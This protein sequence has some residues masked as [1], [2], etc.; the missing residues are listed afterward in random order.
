MTHKLVRVNIIE[1][2]FEIWDGIG[3]PIEYVN[4][5]DTINVQKIQGGMT[6]TLPTPGY[7]YGFVEGLQIGDKITYSRINRQDLGYPPE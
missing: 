5:M 4:T 7:R 3:R 1:E 6:V 2:E